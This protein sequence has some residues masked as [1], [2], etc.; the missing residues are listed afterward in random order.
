MSDQ[1]CG[2]VRRSLG[3]SFDPVP[4]T[5]GPVSEVVTVSEMVMRF[6]DRCFRDA[7]EMR[8]FR[9]MVTSES[10]GDVSPTG[11]GGIENLIAEFQIAASR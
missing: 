11:T 4:F 7:N 8:K 5:C 2:C 6:D 1:T 3:E 9:M 10:L